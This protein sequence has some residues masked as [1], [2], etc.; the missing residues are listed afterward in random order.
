[1][2]TLTWFVW[3][4]IRIWRKVHPLPRAGR[5]R[6][7]DTCPQEPLC[8]SWG[9]CSWGWLIIH[10]MCQAPF[11][12]FCM[13]FFNLFKNHVIAHC[14]NEE[15]RS[16]RGGATYLLSERA[17]TRTPGFDAELLH[18]PLLLGLVSA[19]SST[20]LSHSPKLSPPWA[21]RL[22]GPQ[23]KTGHSSL[24]RNVKRSLESVSGTAWSRTHF[25]AH[26]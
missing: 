5:C 8:R 24:L 21:W 4:K 22:G 1:M 18:R 10:K 19:H 11:W 26:N 2:N 13:C 25:R 17:G 16:Q 6:K 20:I 3:L 14:E 7:E 23:W 15:I 9:Q 12:T